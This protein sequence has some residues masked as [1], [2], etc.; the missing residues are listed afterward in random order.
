MDRQPEMPTVKTNDVNDEVFTVNDVKIAKAVDIITKSIITASKDLESSVKFLTTQGDITAAMT[1]MLNA[2]TSL[3]KAVDTNFENCANIAETVD[4]NFLA[5]QDTSEELNEEIFKVSK[6]HSDYVKANE[7]DKLELKVKTDIR[8]YKTQMII[9]LKN[10]KILSNCNNND[11]IA[12]T[13]KIINEQG[14]SLGRVNM[15]LPKS[16]Q[17]E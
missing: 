6:K 4:N 12:I 1:M 14:L 13:E 15:M 10:D 2:Y 7:N 16:H 11:C 3:A 17:A 5:C 8:H 9:Y